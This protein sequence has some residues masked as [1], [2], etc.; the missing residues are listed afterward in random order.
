MQFYTDPAEH[1]KPV[2]V[3]ERIDEQTSSFQVNPN[4]QASLRYADRGD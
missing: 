2:P 1:S 3:Q 4:A